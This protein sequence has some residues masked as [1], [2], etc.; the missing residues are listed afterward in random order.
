MN[1]LSCL[2]ESLLLHTCYMKSPHKEAKC[3][4]MLRGDGMKRLK[5]GRKRVRNGR[6]VRHVAERVQWLQIPG[7]RVQPNYLV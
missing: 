3:D 1:I 4:V 7:L 5:R 6:R 2:L